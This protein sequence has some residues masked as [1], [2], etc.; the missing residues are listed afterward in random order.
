ME[1]T[2]DK[3]SRV[4]MLLLTARHLTRTQVA[5]GTGIGDST[6]ERL[7]TRARKGGRWTALELEMLSAYFKIPAQV[8]L[9][10][11]DPLLTGVGNRNA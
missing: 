6:F 5:T 8:F 9:D 11:P 3:I 4:V 7:H 1:T 2:D 10:G